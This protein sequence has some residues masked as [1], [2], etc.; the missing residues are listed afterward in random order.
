M[1]TNASDHA[2]D[3]G[4]SPRL[5][6][7]P[8]I[9]MLILLATECLGEFGR[10]WLGFDRE[11]IADGQL[12]RLLTGSF[13]H[14]GWYHW[15]LNEIGLVVLVLLCPQPM[16]GREWVRRLLLLALA[17]AVAL[18]AFSPRIERYAGLS[19][20][21]HG[22]FVLGLLPQARRRDPIGLGCL[23][24]LFAKLAYE[25]IAGAPLSDAAAIGG[26]VATDSHLYGAL[27]ALAYAALFGAGPDGT[28]RGTAPP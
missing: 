20:V 2:R 14:L 18:Y 3:N 22:L 27:A 10:H 8:L 5:W 25:Q 12:W 23:A 19:G 4:F 21:M 11:A 28:H 1:I 15:M 13:V 7:A 9:L 6:R 24:F 16:A 17:M 26:Y